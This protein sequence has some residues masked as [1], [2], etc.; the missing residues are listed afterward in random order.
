[1]SI[2]NTFIA[3]FIFNAYLYVMNSA[4]VGMWWWKWA[5]KLHVLTV[6]LFT[7]YVT[8]C[9]QMTLAFWPFEALMQLLW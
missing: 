1:M 7:C 9:S 6:A 3:T 8:A 2:M 4:F 5:V